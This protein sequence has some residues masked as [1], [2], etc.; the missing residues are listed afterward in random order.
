MIRFLF[1]L[2]KVVLVVVAAVWVA[3]H[4]GRVSLEWDEH[5]VETSAALLAAFI[6][7]LMLLSFWAARFFDVLK[8]TPRLYRM[9]TQLRGYRKGQKLL[10]AAM[11]AIEDEKRGKA[12]SLTRRA[13]KLLGISPAV[14]FIK[15]RIDHVA[16]AVSMPSGASATGRFLAQEQWGEAIAAVNEAQQRHKLSRKEARQQRAAILLERARKSLQAGHAVEAFEQ[17]RQAD[18]LHP[19]WAPAIV[20]SAEA[21]DAQHKPQ[22]AAAL[23]ERA[24]D[25]TPHEQLADAYLALKTGQ[26]DVTRASMV[27]KRVKRSLADPAS[28]LFLARAF[29]RAGMWGAARHHAN[30]LAEEKPGRDAYHLLAQIEELEAGDS[31]SAKEWRKKALEAPPDEAWVCASCKQPHERWQA[32]CSSCGA[33]DALHWQSPPHA[34]RALKAL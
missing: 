30:V 9:H 27:E 32:L 12:R 3:G 15:N 13:E 19:N 23:I 2:L 8:T 34:P 16:V 26:S 7:V 31:E 14:S 10:G 33:F 5:I 25:G 1:A 22:A 28:R 4:A 6:A 24:W 29:A 11:Q 20:L 18:R 17:A 21:L